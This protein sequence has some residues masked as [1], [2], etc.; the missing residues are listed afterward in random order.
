MGADGAGHSH[1]FAEGPG[2]VPCP[3]QSQLNA[4]PM[5]DGSNAQAHAAGMLGTSS[6]LRR[7]PRASVSPS[8]KRQ[9]PGVHIA[10]WERNVRALHAFGARMSLGASGHWWESPATPAPADAWSWLW[11]RGDTTPRGGSSTLRVAAGFGAGGGQEGEVLAQ[12]HSSPGTSGLD[13]RKDTEG[14]SVSPL[15]LSWHPQGPQG[16]E[17][18]ITLCPNK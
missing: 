5:R 3:V 7:P 8:V 17:P 15:L 6:R 1:R 12:H 10:W 13:V 14:P 16:Q 9:R 11:G 2:D 4:N 18:S